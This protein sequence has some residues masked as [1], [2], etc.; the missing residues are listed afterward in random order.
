MRESCVRMLVKTPMRS[1][2]SITN[3]SP[4]WVV[5]EKEATSELSG[6]ARES[7]QGDAGEAA[8]PGD[9]HR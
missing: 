7:I 5:L 3:N 1:Q 4:S 8:T 2:S 6:E 9:R